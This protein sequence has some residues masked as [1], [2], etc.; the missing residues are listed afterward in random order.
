V[1]TG[2]IQNCLTS[3][4]DSSCFN[5]LKTFID[6]GQILGQLSLFRKSVISLRAQNDGGWFAIAGYKKWPPGLLN[7]LDI[8]GQMSPV[9]T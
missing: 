2:D 9:F 7:L 3:V 6:H 4:Y 1:L 8:L 5:V